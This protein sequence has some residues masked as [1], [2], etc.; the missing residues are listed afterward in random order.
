VISDETDSALV[1]IRLMVLDALD[2][3]PLVHDENGGGLEE[4]DA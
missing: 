2:D 3:N 1:P 4:G